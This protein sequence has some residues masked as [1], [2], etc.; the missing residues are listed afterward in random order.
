MRG[1]GL[2]VGQG[3]GC[4]QGSDV[5]LITILRTPLNQ[6]LSPILITEHP[7]PSIKIEKYILGQWKQA[8]QGHQAT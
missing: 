7:C 4:R 6:A 1:E 3:G 2:R 5:R 8:T